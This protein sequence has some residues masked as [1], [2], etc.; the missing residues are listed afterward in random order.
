MERH[1]ELMDNVQSLKVHQTVM[2]GRLAES[3]A[4]GLETKLQAQLAQEMQEMQSKEVVLLRHKCA[5]PS[6]EGFAQ[7]WTRFVAHH[8]GM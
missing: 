5:P 3:E 6:K 1:A 4:S 8:E 2:E 7:G